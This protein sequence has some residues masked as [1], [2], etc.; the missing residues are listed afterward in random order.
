VVL[1]IAKGMTFLHF[2]NIFHRDLKPDNVLVVS[3]HEDADVNVKITDFDTA[4]AYL[5]HTEEGG[6]ELHSS[7]VDRWLGKDDDAV[8]E[9]YLSKNLGTLVYKAPEI[10]AGKT[11]YKIDK[12]DI[13]SFAVLLW[14]VFTRN[15]PFADPP[16][17]K[18]DV[19]GIENFIMGG[20]RLPIPKS[21]PTEISN[22]I[23]SCWQ[24]DPNKRQDFSFLSSK[25]QQIIDGIEGGLRSSKGDLHHSEEKMNG[26][27]PGIPPYD[28]SKVSPL[29]ANLQEHNHKKTQSSPLLI[30]PHRGSAEQI[31]N[32]A[33]SELNAKSK[34]RRGLS[35]SGETP[36]LS[37]MPPGYVGEMDRFEAEKKLGNEPGNYLVRY[38]KDAYVISYVSNEGKFMHIRAAITSSG[39]KVDSTSGKSEEFES[40]LSLT[41]TMIRRKYIVKPIV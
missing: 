4:R 13:F 40:L 37:E 5:T 36:K 11:K 14:Q 10:I 25:L 39:L 7:K 23:E 9:K 30:S 27:Y 17:D 33:N 12:C 2:N 19:R 18:M 34:I 8:P 26:S 20:M 16:Y 3:T 15:K 31:P 41:N 24:Q 35:I 21:V 29:I 28:P 22:L 6:N 38:S 32:R 1:D